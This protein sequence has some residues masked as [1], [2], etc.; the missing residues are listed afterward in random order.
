MTTPR[1]LCVLTV[2][3]LISL[4][5]VFSFRSVAGVE[6][7]QPTTTCGWAARPAGILDERSAKGR[8]AQR[9]R[10]AAILRRRSSRAMRRRERRVHSSLSQP[11]GGFLTSRKRRPERTQL[12]WDSVETPTARAARRSARSGA[13]PRRRAS[14][15]LRSRWPADTSDHP[16]IP[17]ILYES[18]HTFRVIPMDGRPHVAE[19]Q[20]VDGRLARPLGGQHARGGRDEF[21]R[22]DLVRLAWELPQR[23]PARG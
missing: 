14:H 3:A 17:T 15:Q 12:L 6:Q 10:T 11:T 13:G 1:A 8:G 19:R 7:R 20:V 22:Q 18:S 5:A 2:A 9:R 4:A 23:G 16:D 21:Q